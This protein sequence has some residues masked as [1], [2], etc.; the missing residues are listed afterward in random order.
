MNN[1]DFHPHGD[2]GIKNNYLVVSAQ[3]QFTFSGIGYYK[4]EFFAGLKQGKRALAPLIRE[5]AN[6]DAI[7]AD[8]Y[9]GLWSDVGTPHRLKALQNKNE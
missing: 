3:E 6:N 9:T 5:H 1:P 8:L 2:F 7:K 4:K